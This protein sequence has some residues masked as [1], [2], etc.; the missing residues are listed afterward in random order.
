MKS[1]I[2]VFLAVF[3]HCTTIAQYWK[4]EDY[5]KWNQKNFRTCALFH[6]PIQDSPTDYA[7]LDAAIFYLTNEERIKNGMEPLTYYPLLEVSA[8]GHSKAMAE[9]E[10]FSHENPNSS[11]RATPEKRATLAGISNP[12][13]AENIA[14]YL[15]VNDGSSYLEYAKEF[16]ELWMES[17]GH[18]SN[19]LSGSAIS[20]G[21]GVFAK[22]DEIYAT[23]N[24][25]WF[26][27]IKESS[28]KKDKFL[29]FIR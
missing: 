1:N 2:L 9:Q 16:V 24:F 5:S 4:A 26:E 18:R 8:Y 6:A 7:L 28:K 15:F 14:M 10:F 3:S 23:Q 25:Q 19:I 22:D 27:P 11:L 21:C 29:P 13:I 20:M 12:Y 17:P